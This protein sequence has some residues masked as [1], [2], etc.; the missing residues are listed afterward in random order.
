MSTANILNFCVRRFMKHNVYGIA[1]L[2][3]G[4]IIL[5]TYLLS[6]IILPIFP[7]IRVFKKELKQV[8]YPYKAQQE[9]P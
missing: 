3:C 7:S 5:L 6:L 9:Q 8:L 1:L 4:I 2:N